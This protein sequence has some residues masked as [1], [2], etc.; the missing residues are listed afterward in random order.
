MADLLVK[1]GGMRDFKKWGDPSN[2]LGKMIL[3]WGEGVDTPVQTIHSS[4]PLS[5]VLHE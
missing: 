4:L 3:K 5:N 2:E 1:W